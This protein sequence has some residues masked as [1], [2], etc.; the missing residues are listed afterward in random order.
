CNNQGFSGRGCPGRREEASSDIRKREPYPL[1]T[2]SNQ[3]K[4][5][6]GCRGQA[7]NARQGRVCLL[8]RKGDAC[9]TTWRNIWRHIN[10][11]NTI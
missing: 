3:F 7:C 5:F 4:H 10:Q 2:H 6:S 11:I 1:R 8:W 9:P